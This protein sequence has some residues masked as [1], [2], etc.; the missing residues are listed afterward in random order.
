[1][2]PE[3]VNVWSK[4]ILL[5]LVDAIARDYYSKPIT[6]T[7][8]DRLINSPVGRNLFLTLSVTDRF[9]M[10]SKIYYGFY[11]EHEVVLSLAQRCYAPYLLLVITERDTFMK[12]TNFEHYNIALTNVS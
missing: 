8:I 12:A 3:F 7:F 1:M 10:V 4:E 5:N 6:I 11:Q 9:G 2:G